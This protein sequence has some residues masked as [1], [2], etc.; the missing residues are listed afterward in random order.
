MGDCI[1]FSLGCCQV[2][3]IIAADD[4]NRANAA[5]ISTASP[6]TW[7][8]HGG[9][10]PLV[11]NTAQ[12]SSIGVTNFSELDVY[13]NNAVDDPTIG[14]GVWVNPSNVTFD[15]GTDYANTPTPSSAISDY[16]S[17]TNFNFSPFTIPAD[18]TLTGIQV[19]FWV[20]S[21]STQPDLACDNVVSLVING[22][23]SGANRAAAGSWPTSL[24]WN[25]YGGS[26]DLWG[27]GPM[28]LADVFASN[29]GAAISAASFA[30]GNYSGQVYACRISVY[31]Q[32]TNKNVAFG[33]PSNI[34]L[35]AAQPCTGYVSADV[36]SSSDG[37]KV[38]VGLSFGQPPVVGVPHFG[39][40]YKVW[41]ELTVGTAAQIAILDG[42]P[43]TGV[44]DFAAATALATADVSVAINQ[45]HNL[46][47]SY[48]TPTVNGIRALTAWLDGVPV[49]AIYSMSLSTFDNALGPGAYA[50]GG[51]YI[52]SGEV[53]NG[54][55]TFDNYQVSLSHTNLT[56]C[57]QFGYCHWPVGPTLPTTV[58]VVISG[59]TGDSAVFNGTFHLNLDT[60]NAD[61]AGFGDFG[62]RSVAC[63][64]YSAAISIPYNFTL[65]GRS[66]TVNK[67][68]FGASQLGSGSS[69]GENLFEVRLI[70]TG[71]SF[72]VSQ[73]MGRIDIYPPVAN[74]VTN[75]NGLS[76]TANDTSY[77]LPG[78]SISIPQNIFGWAGASVS[79]GGVTPYFGSYSTVLITTP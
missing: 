11:G 55:A 74:N 5:S 13:T 53:L 36:Q 12:C 59:M 35:Q 71:L 27:L 15:D 14:A 42:G 49:I 66:G 46:A 64:C 47:L 25:S 18:A 24:T 16:L 23:V 39:E 43:W 70:Q 65:Y 61:C 52:A 58:T 2:S 8:F 48:D 62:A 40:G 75:A 17:C 73:W 57:P 37:D 19:E 72:P 1:K 41:A 54:T 32:V 6:I 79:G 50:I 44:G 9:S 20:A 4:F 29:F 63:S 38:R 30:G 34:A 67:I 77:Y 60:V 22:V 21:D 10:F 26:T 76:I 33:A 56:G 28:P 69:T 3:C 78:T 45:S 31:W 7:T 68:Y 51:G